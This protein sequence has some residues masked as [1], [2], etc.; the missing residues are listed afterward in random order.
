MGLRAPWYDSIEII[1]LQQVK[2][3]GMNPIGL[4]SPWTES[5]E[6]IFYNH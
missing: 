4:N 2:F 3:Q 1:A 6:M 5:I